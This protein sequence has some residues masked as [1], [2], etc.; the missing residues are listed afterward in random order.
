MLKSLEMFGFKS[1]ADRTAFEFSP[2]V[3]C[4]VGPNGSGK[5]NVVDALKWILGDQSPKS[6]RGKDMADVIFN[7]SAGR[8]PSGFAEATLTFDNS[9]EL[10]PIDTQQVQIGRR[11]YRSGDSEYLLNGSAVRLKDIRDLFMGTGA[12]TAAYSIIEQ[13]RVDQILQANPTTRRV[14]FE[15][16]AGISKFKTRRVD[17]ER[18]LDRVAQNL[19][20]LRDIV[21]EVE[22]QLTATRSQA[23]KAAKYRELS[24]ELKE[25]WTGLAA[26]DYRHLTAELTGL[27][28]HGQARVDELAGLD[29][30]LAGLE[31]KRSAIEEKLSERD[32]ELREFERT[33]SSNRE[34]IAAHE[35]AIRY[36]SGRLEEL[37]HE[38]LQLRQERNSLRTG[39]RGIARELET[40]AQRL[41]EFQQSFEEQRE[42]LL[43]REAQISG[44]S[45]Q[46]ETVRQALRTA[47]STRDE[48]VAQR[49]KSAERVTTL[50]AQVEHAE[51]A[52]SAIQAKLAA[53]DERLQAAHSEV[54][55]R[56][57]RLTEAELAAESARQEVERIRSDRMQLAGGQRETE[58]QL[59]E[60]REQRSAGQARLRVLEDLERRQEGLGIGVREILRRAHEIDASPW[61][62][63]LGTAS[64]LL[65]V[66][67]EKAPLLDVALGRRSQLIVIRELRPLLDY[68]NRID[69]HISGR[70]GFIEWSP[71]A[72]LAGQMP[73]ASGSS[74]GNGSEGNSL[75]LSDRLPDLSDIPG[76]ACRADEL[77][78]EAE[79]VAGLL[80]RLLADT[81]IVDTLDVA[82]ELASGAGRECRFVTLQGELIERDRTLFVGTVPHETAVVSR[83]SELLKLKDELNRLD[84]EIRLAT[85]RLSRLADTLEDAGGVLSGAEQVLRDRLDVCTELRSQ[86]NTA[87]SETRR[88]EDERAALKEEADSLTERRDGVRGELENAKA[89]VAADDAELKAV[90]AEIVDRR[91]TIASV[92][93]SLQQSRSQTS[94]EQVD[95]AKHEER[96]ANLKSSQERLERDRQLR[97]QQQAEAEARLNAA[98]QTHRRTLL[99]ILQTESELAS[100][101]LEAEERARSI[102]RIQQQRAAVQQERTEL[103][104]HENELTKR[105][106]TLQ[107]ESHQAEIRIREIRHQLV[108]LAERIE[109][110]YQVPLTEFVESGVS[111]L[112]QY[113][114]QRSG[115]AEKPA[116]SPAAAEETTD[117]ES[118]AAAETPD[119]AEETTAAVSE[120]VAAGSLPDEPEITLEDIRDELEGRV[121]RL[122]R[123][124]KLMGTVNTDALQDLEELETRY[125]HL[126][127]QLNDLEEAK[128]T[129]EEIIRR[130]NV[131]SKRLFLETFEA[132]QVNFRDLFRKL[133]GGGEGDIILEDPD[134]VLE[135]GIDIVARPPG[136]E[137]RS[138]SLL[139]GGEKTM[140]AVALLFAMFKSK[141][142]PYC[143]L[144]EVDAALDDANV[145]RYVSVV[146]EFTDMTQ[147]V[148]ITH[149]KPTM[150][151]A[152]VL[153]GVTMEQAG[154]SKRMSVRFEEVGENGEIRTQS[155]KAA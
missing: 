110:E 37:E 155:G 49:T 43:Q 115:N 92:E 119:E 80:T 31:S 46:L 85:A 44:L 69:S 27:E 141:P 60:Y 135:C 142:S 25:L 134:N 101:F 30:E 150:T 151:A 61:N 103:S 81:W 67:L 10:L 47:Q 58:R 153:Y 136:K 120:T 73:S 41:E 87:E 113:R 90:D 24:R 17:A 94:A 114:Q 75:L 66:S 133:F 137:L 122:R 96:L 50:S 109:E 138:I 65:E 88:L 77:A 146:K 20:R 100:C 139:S 93:E 11:L 123:K 132:I 64:D 147:F 104:R 82:F 144:D 102:H 79:P 35:S 107:D 57:A 55:T 98:R 128:S 118:D 71:D 15:E 21:D 140:T 59:N 45:E 6:L 152:D 91:E 28:D 52:V 99:T 108:T 5:S 4:V 126:S 143:I 53:H 63:I 145:D 105:R 154:V 74:E 106:R 97:E 111:A 38:I 48:L 149:R 12:G 33:A 40:T 124:L 32:R 129:L 34:T 26:D 95:L 19:L 89:Q 148:I 18:K 51:A 112:E 39:T 76:V 130:I 42:A 7:G 16:A 72:P 36:Q 78:T 83:R 2:G 62:L 22:A 13:G 127:S 8:R 117:A 70:V 131:E 125:E 29:E 68:L 14:V 56:Q 86:L 1:F 54:E 84:H 23:S 121:N 3:T 116:V 9:S